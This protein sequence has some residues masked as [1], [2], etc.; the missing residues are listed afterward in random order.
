[1]S[2]NSLNF[3]GLQH[4]KSLEVQ[5]FPSQSVNNKNPK[6]E[7]NLAYIK[8]RWRCLQVFLGILFMSNAI[9]SFSQIAPPK[10]HWRRFDWASQNP[11]ISNSAASSQTFTRK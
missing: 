2:S 5:C 6:S 4:G 1:M 10:V 7:R 3:K 8:A 11:I 9:D